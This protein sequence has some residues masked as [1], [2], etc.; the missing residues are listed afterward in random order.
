VSI[1]LRRQSRLPILRV[2][3]GEYQDVA[4]K[5]RAVDPIE[6]G[7]IKIVVPGK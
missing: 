7:E 1:I 3:P 5:L 6:Q 2:L 4:A